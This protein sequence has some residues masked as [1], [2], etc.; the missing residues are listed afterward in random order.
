MNCNGLSNLKFLASDE[1]GI[2]TL[3]VS[4]YF[5]W[6]PRSKLI[7]QMSQLEPIVTFT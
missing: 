6:L 1:A 3:D 4:H 2:M 5:C 7:D